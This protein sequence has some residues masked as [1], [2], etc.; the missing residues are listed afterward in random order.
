MSEG[1]R[2]PCRAT[3]QSW[4][5]VTTLPAF[6]FGVTAKIVKC[7]S[8]GLGRTLP[9]PRIDHSFY[10]DNAR[11]IDLFWRRRDLY[12]SFARQ[13][14]SSLEGLVVP[15]EKR[16][17]DVGC[18][19]GFLIEVAQ[20]LGYVAEGMEANTSLVQWCRKRNLQV[21]QGDVLDTPTQGRYDVIVLAAILEHLPEPGILLHVCREMLNPGGVVLASQASYDGLLPS[22]FPWGWYG[23]QPQEHYWHF[24]VGSFCRLATQAGFEMTRVVRGTLHHPWFTMGTPKEFVGRNIAASIARIGARVGRGDSFNT[25]LSLR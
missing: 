8:C 21:V 19:A 14:L 5:R 2:C 22:V 15:T 11:Y 13:L 20:E 9:C 7:S 24:D 10:E 1:K 6:I 12:R 18:G 16:L 23:W 4:L 3:Q 25:V 17:W